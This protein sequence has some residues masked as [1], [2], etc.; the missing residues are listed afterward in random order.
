MKN[1]LPII[2]PNNR[3]EVIVVDKKVG[4]CAPPLLFGRYAAKGG[5]APFVGAQGAPFY[6]RFRA[7]KIY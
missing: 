6:F 7:Q 1:A 4:R 3:R 5:F 2:N